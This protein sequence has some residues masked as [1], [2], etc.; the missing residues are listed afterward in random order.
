[1]RYIALYDADFTTHFNTEELNV[2]QS[3]AIASKPDDSSNLVDTLVFQRFRETMLATQLCRANET[4]AIELQTTKEITL[5][6]IAFSSIIGVPKG[7]INIRFDDNESNWIEQ[8]I[9]VKSKHQ[10]PRN[11]SPFSEN[12]V[13]KPQQI[14]SVHVTLSKDVVFYRSRTISDS[15]SAKDFDVSLEVRSGRDILSHF[16]FTT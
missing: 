2:T 11:F 7:W 3:T 16:F 8:R 14:Y 6:G 10:E 12:V 15:Y 4:V 5:T 13:L 1:M 9:N